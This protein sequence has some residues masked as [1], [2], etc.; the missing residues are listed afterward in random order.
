MQF[1]N[2]IFLEKTEAKTWDKIFDIKRVSNA[3]ESRISIFELDFLENKKCFLEVGHFYWARIILWHIVPFY[4]DTEDKFLNGTK[5]KTVI[6]PK[7][8][9]RSNN[10]ERYYTYRRSLSL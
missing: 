3:C 5:N 7:T 1:A 6:F 10:C 8:K 9:R 4:R 2:T